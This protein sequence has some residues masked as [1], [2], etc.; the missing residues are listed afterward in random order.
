MTQHVLR[1]GWDKTDDTVSASTIGWRNKRCWFVH[2]PAQITL[3]WTSMV[4]TNTPRTTTKWHTGT[5][6]WVG[7]PPPGRGRGRQAAPRVAPPA[8]QQAPLK[9]GVP[10]PASRT[11]WLPDQQGR[12]AARP[13]C[14]AAALTCPGSAGGRCAR[15]GRSAGQGGSRGRATSGGGSGG[16]TTGWGTQ[17][18]AGVSKKPGRRAAQ[19]HWA[20]RAAGAGTGAPGGSRQAG[21]QAGGRARTCSMPA[22]AKENSSWRCSLPTCSLSSR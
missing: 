19:S 1:P 12:A 3:A 4:Q 21:R 18:V 2:Q 14:T 15:A 6:W 8:T 11:P 20:Q 10:L 13:A 9:K 22:A 7:A 5:W 16:G 17:Q